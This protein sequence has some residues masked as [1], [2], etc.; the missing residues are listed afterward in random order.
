I[1][2]VAVRL[3]QLQFTAGRRQFV[4]VS[5]TSARLTDDTG[6]Y[7]IFGVPPGQYVV[8]A[9]VP[10]QFELTTVASGNTTM[11]PGANL[12]GY[13]PTYFPGATA[14]AEARIISVGL[15]QELST[16]DFRLMSAATARITG[17]A[18]GSRAEPM[19][20]LM[21]R[22]GRSGGFAE[23]PLRASAD[24]VGGFHFD[25]VPPGEY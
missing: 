21:R 2:G 24:A 9:T 1:E 3:M 15:S 18:R 11:I 20:V 23:R 8:L 22:S 6:S 5:A 12:P 17:V 13:A 16:I 14:P 25:N 10:A 7:R 4:D 19:G